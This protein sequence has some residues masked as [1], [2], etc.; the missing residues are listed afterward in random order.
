MVIMFFSICKDYGALLHNI[1][2]KVL[3]SYRTGDTIKEAG[4]KCVRR[5]YLLLI[6]F[7]DEI[8]DLLAKKNYKRGKRRGNPNKYEENFN[9]C[10]NS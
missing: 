9:S 3:M 2:K 5:N 1:V 10:Q 4:R 6:I 8:W 7:V